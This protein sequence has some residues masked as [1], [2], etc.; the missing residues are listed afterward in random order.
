MP[1]DA[2][3]VQAVFLAAVEAADPAARVAVLDR[4]CGADAE[5]RLRVEVLLKAHDTEASILDG[6]DL[7]GAIG[8]ESANPTDTLAELP[9]AEG[10][11]HELEF[12][13]SP[14]RPDSLGRLGHY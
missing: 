14:T 9:G 8:T 6:P 12:L 2:K 1:T 5:M 4:E 7:A 11:E 10:G 3:R 13:Q